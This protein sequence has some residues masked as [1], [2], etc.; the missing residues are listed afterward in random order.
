VLQPNSLSSAATTDYLRMEQGFAMGCSQPVLMQPV[1]QDRTETPPVEI[2][3]DLYSH[4][5][6]AMA[7]VG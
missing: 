7:I 2:W 6:L 1:L 4:T 3:H 5:A